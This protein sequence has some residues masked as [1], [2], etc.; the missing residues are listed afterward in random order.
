MNALTAAVSRARPS[1]SVAATLGFALTGSAAGVLARCADA[2]PGGDV[3]AMVSGLAVWV[4]SLALIAKVSPGA[5]SAAVRSAAFFLGMVAAY[6]AVTVYVLRDLVTPR[7]VVAW[8]VAAFT[9]CPAVAAVSEKAF[10]SRRIIAA[11]PIGIIAGSVF[12]D[13]AMQRVLLALEDPDLGLGTR[14]LA[15]GVEVLT[16]VVIVIL[17][18]RSGRVRVLGAAIA[19][20]TSLV[21]LPVIERLVY[22]SG[23][24]A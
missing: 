6:Y 18:P 11:V 5:G 14:P 22:G 2:I 10:R 15:A 16:A 3:S 17:L 4:L 7:L 24:F 8:G 1:S 19:V 21:L 20:I 23:L 12:V 13:G 9:A